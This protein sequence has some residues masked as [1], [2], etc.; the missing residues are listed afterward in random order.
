[1]TLTIS[2]NQETKELRIR[3]PVKFDFS[4][5]QDF[6]K[7]ID[8]NQKEIKT[9]VI[10]LQATDYLDS[11]ALGMLLILRDKMNDDKNS[12]HLIHAKPEV[13]KILK[14]ANFDQLFSLK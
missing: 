4:V 13:I 9:I 10:D 6:R 7:A 11:A 8:W 1:M 2:H 12:V 5:H 14:I 3:T